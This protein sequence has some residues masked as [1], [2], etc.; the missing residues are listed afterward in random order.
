M[1]RR[2]EWAEPTAEPE[3]VPTQAACDGESGSV[4]AVSPHA[5]TVVHKGDTVTVSLCTG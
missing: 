1:T 2:T 5:P 3:P 4:V